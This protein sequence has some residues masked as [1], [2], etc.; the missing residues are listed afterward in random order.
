[1]EFVKKIAEI[2]ENVQFRQATGDLREGSIGI[3]DA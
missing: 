2:T 3:L 1:M